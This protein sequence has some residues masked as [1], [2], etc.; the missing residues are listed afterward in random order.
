M[1]KVPK[2]T[3][4]RLLRQQ[5]ELRAKF[6]EKG[7]RRVS[8]GK[9]KRCGKDSEVL[10]RYFMEQGFS[11]TLTAALDTCSDAVRRKA[12]AR[13]PLVQSKS[14]WTSSS[15]ERTVLCCTCL[16]H[17]VVLY[18]ACVLPQRTS[19]FRKPV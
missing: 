19:K 15:R 10:E 4:G 12:S 9:R 14:P 7:K 6:R 18:L 8:L 2:T 3:I 11:E 13:A 1:L 17:C 16:S 5:G